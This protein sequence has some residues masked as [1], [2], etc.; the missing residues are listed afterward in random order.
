MCLL[1]PFQLNKVASRF[2]PPLQSGACISSLRWVNAPSTA[3]APYCQKVNE[4]EFAGRIE[5]VR[6]G[7]EDP[8]FE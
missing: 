1:W 3:R 5:W 8:S 7:N 6:K 2:A 4:G